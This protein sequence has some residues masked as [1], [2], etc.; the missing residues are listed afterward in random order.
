MVKKRFGYILL[1]SFMALTVTGAV[2]CSK[3]EAPAPAK[4]GSVAG[5]PKDAVIT[6]KTA[7]VEGKQVERSVEAVGTLAAWDEVMVSSET[8]GIV[9]KIH[10]D[11]GD[12]VKAG[13]VL[14]VLD[15]R[16]AS[17]A[18]EDARATHQTNLKGLERER[19]RLEDA[20][21]TLKRYDELFKQG[22]V[23]ASQ[24]DN[25]RTAH[26]VA[27]AQSR[28][29]EAKVDGSS[30]RL[31]LAKKRLGD[32]V[33]RS[34]ITGEVS[35]RLVNTGES[36]KDKTQMF[37]VVSTGTLKFRGTVA[38]SAVPYI[39]PEQTVSVFVEAFS[40]K[41]FKGKLKRISPAIDVQT[42]TLEVEAAVPNPG[43]LLKP[44]YFARGVILTG[45]EANVPFVPESAVYNFVG[46]NKVFVISGETA[47]ERL[48]KTGARE[49]GMVEIINNLKPGETVATTNLSN[50]FEG[51][52]VKVQD[53]TK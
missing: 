36:I 23:S 5:A 34:P 4:Q 25:A 32:T 9:E 2:G 7:L 39:K 50:L 21:T 33:I 16:E 14:A 3:K 19:A 38:E 46:I 47:G 26:D 22:M 18:L 13:D 20:K 27:V 52:K 37:T 31:N 28:E 53:N 41:S 42:R 40:G 48:I 44:G 43:N 15:Q 12:K 29:A 24:F 30:A 51:A 45:T 49:K 6:V 8:P 35:K 1:A 17:L 10:R 11:L